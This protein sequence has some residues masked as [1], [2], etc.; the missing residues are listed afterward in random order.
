M[1]ELRHKLP[2][3]R[4]SRAS[5][6]PNAPTPNDDAIDSIRS[7]F[8]Q[9]K[10]QPTGSTEDDRAMIQYRDAAE[11][12]NAEAQFYLG[13]AYYE[14]SAVKQSYS[15]AVRWWQMAAEQGHAAAQHQLG[16]AYSEGEGVQ[17]NTVIAHMWYSLS[18]EE[19]FFL[20]LEC[21]TRLRRMN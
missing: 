10:E 14:G 2:W 13:E 9:K 5:R 19:K 18:S 21:F 15:N 11:R 17:K 20:S 1:D 12:G 16:C 4:N 6:R 3:R 7:S 8:P